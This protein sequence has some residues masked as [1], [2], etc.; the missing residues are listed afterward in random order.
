[1][2]GIAE[3]GLEGDC[4]K[5]NKSRAVQLKAM[6]VVYD[7]LIAEKIYYIH[8]IIVLNRL[9]HINRILF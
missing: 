4:A 6:V 8:E 9:C 1:M 3:E 2:V 5:H 7:I